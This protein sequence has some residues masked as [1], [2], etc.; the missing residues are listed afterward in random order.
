MNHK[1]LMA[2]LKSSFNIFNDV[3]KH[4][5]IIYLDYPVH[6]NIGDLLIYCGAMAWF[7]ENDINVVE[8]FSVYDL[9]ISK[10]HKLSKKYN[11]KI[12]LICHGGG[13]FGD[14]YKKHQNLRK[15]IVE[16]FPD[17]QIIIFPQTIF[18]QNSINLLKDAKIFLQHVNLTLFVRDQ[19]SLDIGKQLCKKVL[20]SPDIAHMLWQEDSFLEIKKNTGYGTLIF[21]RKDIESTFHGENGFDW[22]DI[23]EEEDIKRLHKV[24][25]YLKY[26]LFRKKTQQKWMQQT[27]NLCQLA[28][29]HFMK[30]DNINT[31]RLHGHILSCLLSMDHSVLD[32]SYGKNSAYINKWTKESDKLFPLNECK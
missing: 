26:G 4:K 1:Q 18:Y 22:K 2:T 30:H 7:K 31:D 12:T 19:N 6:H 29:K 23:I 32:N 16:S 15:N 28:A 21:R 14:L 24:R 9:N 27:V 8:Q 13:N 25:K 10:I 17:L 5:N 20:L 11:N 3:I